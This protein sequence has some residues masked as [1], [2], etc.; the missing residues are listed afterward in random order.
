MA[1]AT[2]KKLPALTM[3]GA[4][5]N[6]SSLKNPPVKKLGKK[7]FLPEMISTA[8]EYEDGGNSGAR[9][10]RAGSILR[11]SRFKNIEDGITPFRNSNAIYDNSQSGV[12]IRDAV[13]LCQKCYWNFALFRNII[14]LMTEFSIDDIL[15]AGG[16]MQSRK[17]FE[18]LFNKI[19]IWDLQDKFYREYYR[20]GNVFVYRFDAT[21]EP[22]DVKKIIT[23]LASK[24]S[25][26]NPVL[27][28]NQPMG[29]PENHMGYPTGFPKDPKG[30]NNPLLQ[31]GPVKLEVEPMKMPARY[32][33]LNPA[34]INM[35]GT[36]NFSYGIYYKILTEYEVSRLR[37]LQTEEDIE[38]FNTLPKFTQDQ[39]RAGV[40]SVYIPLDTKKVKIVFYKKQ[41]YEP[42]AVPM[43][44]PVLED[45]N[46][47]IEMRRIDMAICRTMQQI[48]LLVTAGAE[49]DK[50]GINQKHLETLTKIFKNESVGRVLVA[51]YTTK[52]SFVIPE[53][54]DLLDPK[55]YE[56]IDRDINIGLNNVFLGGEKFA[57]QQKKVEIF[58]KRLEQA[59]ESFLNNFLIPEIKR[60]AKSLNFKSYPTPYYDSNQFKDDVSYAKLY[61]QLATVGILTPD[62]CVEAIQNNRLPESD[63]MEP[64]QETYKTQRKN[65]LYVPLVP[66]PPVPGAK[67]GTTAPGQT[68][69]PQGTSGI[70]QT[71][72]K[73][74]PM[75]SKGSADI[76]ISLP[77]IKDNMI[78]AQE[79]EKDIIAFL[80]KKHK[81]KKLTN[82]Q[83]SVASGI[84]T[85]I[86]SNEESDKWQ[87][88][89][90]DYCS[91]PV[92]KNKERVSAVL[93]MA[94]AHQVDTYLGALFY[95][96]RATEVP[97]EPKEA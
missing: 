8:S 90:K 50:G 95:S 66:P 34:D 93:D 24:T 51:D 89:V 88:S 29:G 10:D 58:V 28:Q 2:K 78:I 76:K 33:I 46:A 12:D 30:D 61:A 47:K 39:I 22:G 44:Y 57:N 19:N 97:E 87:S 32:I 1:K 64:A 82:L 14:D 86:M 9:R 72:K 69:R 11:T 6:K 62:Q 63:T 54:A 70:P 75:G 3:I 91:E 4:Q 53:I 23:S 5:G 38:V 81:V 52:A 27:E 80:K 56:V 79:T 43:G 96:S 18:A 26:G 84:L 65:G 83:N 73:I 71:T 60:I 35:L 94:Y 68:G 31:D 49:P 48:V 15:Y 77:K 40:R 67:L 13:I 41:D 59:K 37:N 42:F 21:V 36:A 55:K 74:T 7:S 45:I 85:T 92:D 16:N 20:S 17:F 25:V